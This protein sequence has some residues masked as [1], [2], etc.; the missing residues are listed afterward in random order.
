MIKRNYR[1]TTGL[2][3]NYLAIFIFFVL[4]DLYVWKTQKNWLFEKDSF[5]SGSHYSQSVKK[6]LEKSVNNALHIANDEKT[7]AEERFKEHLRIRV[8]DTCSLAMEMYKNLDKKL[9]KE[10]LRFVMKRELSKLSYDNQ[11]GSFFALSHKDTPAGNSLSVEFGLNILTDGQGAEAIT[12]MNEILKV[13]FEKKEGFYNLRLNKGNEESLSYNKIA[14]FAYFEPLD[15][16]IGTAGYPRQE[17]AE[18]QE[19]AIKSIKQLYIPKN[20]CLRIFDS[21]GNIILSIHNPSSEKNADN[22][23]ITK[24]PPE[25]YLQLKKAALNPTG[26]FIEYYQDE[27]I[28]TI[29][30]KNDSPPSNT[31]DNYK[32]EAAYA[33]YF[34]EWN[35]LFLSE[36]N[37]T[38]FDAS[39]AE[40]TNIAVKLVKSRL[41]F[42]IS[43][44]LIFFVLSFSAI[45]IFLRKLENEVESFVCF[46]END[47]VK[48]KT[49]EPGLFAF[50]ESKKLAESANR[51]VYQAQQA[52]K[53][54]SESEEKYR[55]FVER[56]NDGIIILQDLKIKYLNPVASA[57]FGRSVDALLEKNFIDMMHTFDIPVFL[58][59]Y[60]KTIKGDNDSAMSE[61]RIYHAEGTERHIEINAGK[62]MFKG[63][64]AYLMVTRDI[65]LRKIEEQEKR[66]IEAQIQHAQKLESL[67]VL[68]GGIAHDFN[69]LLLAILGNAAIAMKEM[70]E[71]GLTCSRLT[72]IQT[73]AERAAELIRQ[74]LAYSGKGKFI[75]KPLDLSYIVEEMAHLLEI[76]IEKKAQFKFDFQKKLPLINGDATQ[77]RQVIMNLITN[78]ADAMGEKY[79]L[80][81]LKTGTTVF[82]PDDTDDV[83]IGGEP[84]GKYVYLQVID[85]GCGM[86]KQTVSK[87]FD[88]FFTTK[89]TG[90]GLGLAAVL[91]IVRGH[92]GLLK[93]ESEPGVGTAFTVMFPATE[94]TADLVQKPESSIEHWKGSG[95]ILV[96]DDEDA[97]R[98]VATALLNDF[99]FS[100]LTASDGED[101]VRIFRENQDEIKA[102]LLDLTM[103][104][105]NGEEAFYEM[106]KIRNDVKVVISSGYSEQAAMEHFSGEGLAGFI[107]KPYRVQELISAIRSAVQTSQNNIS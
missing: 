98:E 83:Y 20:S 42:I 26:D 28:L 88:P 15:W 78:A 55:S 65:T 103:P 18:A 68:A 41:L 85:N 57:F 64:A 52:R 54:L 47:A 94:T 76:A 50:K 5:K 35:W 46:L 67:G 2:F 21:E 93:V 19:N 24:I 43:L 34:K 99:G 44:F 72:A 81:Q 92:N 91:G 77:I 9:D 107:Q 105:M 69:N 59:Q 101:G 38:Y 4:I 74:L 62:I 79:G 31:P 7:K 40:R 49:I 33:K 30:K 1:I 10:S 63:K 86:N 87:I 48:G 22:L 60:E 58:E 27:K 70:Q 6:L 56:A 89:F 8:K 75:I 102:V 84:H 104:N 39:I 90:R 14:Y 82:N 61:I 71:K 12:A 73:S 17:I 16:I 53:E 3:Y 37:K 36:I 11:A 23:K 45:K 66:K 80:I 32:R 96:V 100:T 25:K 97:V 106:K 95:T 13:A 29:G 51:M